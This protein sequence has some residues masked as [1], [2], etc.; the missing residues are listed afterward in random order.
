MFSLSAEQTSPFFELSS[1]SV[2]RLEA[3]NA[4]VWQCGNAAMRQCPMEKQLQLP[5]TRKGTGP[6]QR[7][8]RSTGNHW[9][10][11]WMSAHNQRPTHSP[12]STI[13][14]CSMSIRRLYLGSGKFS[15]FPWVEGL[16]R[17]S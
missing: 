13:D 14:E 4:A 17:L 11:G 7:S 12:Q 2:A 9:M 6:R 15:S 5:W 10:H 8:C 3:C 1:S 16:A